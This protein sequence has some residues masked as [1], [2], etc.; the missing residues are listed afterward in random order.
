[1]QTADE[2][3]P[4]IVLKDDEEWPGDVLFNVQPIM[5]TFVCG[6]GSVISTIPEPIRLAIML[7][8]GNWYENREATLVSQSGQSSIVTIPFTVDALLADYRMW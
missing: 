2:Y 5:I 4:S 7:L 3:H 6:Y 8:V 1:V